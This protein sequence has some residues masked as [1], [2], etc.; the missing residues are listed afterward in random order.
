MVSWH[1]LVPNPVPIGDSSR[2]ERGTNLRRPPGDGSE[3]PS[4][5]LRKAEDGNQRHKHCTGEQAY[6]PQGPGVS[7]LQLSKF[8]LSSGDAKRVEHS[9]PDYRHSTAAAAAS[10]AAAATA[11][12]RN[13]RAKLP[14]PTARPG[15]RAEF[16]I[17]AAKPDSRWPAAAE[18]REATEWKSGEWD[19]KWAFVKAQENSK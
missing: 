17:S 11:P 16:T 12:A 1:T 2:S 4:V 10:P 15:T 5:L 7:L 18:R 14:V 3:Q 13:S 8:L 19:A 6:R 9:I